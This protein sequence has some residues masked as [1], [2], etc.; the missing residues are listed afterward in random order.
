MAL[1]NVNLF[2]E[3]GLPLCDL[4]LPE[5]VTPE[6]VIASLPEQL[7]TEPVIN[8]LNNLRTADGQ[9]GTALLAPALSVPTATRG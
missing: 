3:E 4:R 6:S 8:A 5:G 7:R 9:S 1:T 2:I